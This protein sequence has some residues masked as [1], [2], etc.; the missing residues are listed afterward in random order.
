MFATSTSVD[1]DEWEIC[2][3]HGFV[4]K[5]R[6]ILHLPDNEDDVCTLLHPRWWPLRPYSV[7]TAARHS[8]ASV[9]STSTSSPTGNP[10][11]WS[12]LRRTSGFSRLPS[13]PSAT[14][15]PP[16]SSSDL[17]VIDDLLA[18]V[19]IRSL[20]LFNPTSKICNLYQTAMKCTSAQASGVPSSDVVQ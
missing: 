18:Q 10:S 8:S 13:D 16:N 5:R 9:P 15:P 7:A 12:S 20:I 19:Y 4:Y 1:G 2:N 3:Y 6:Q 14:S 17:D 11:P